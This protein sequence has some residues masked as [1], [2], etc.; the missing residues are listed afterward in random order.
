V[1]AASSVP[2]VLP[3]INPSVVPGLPI[4]YHPGQVIV[5]SPTPPIATIPQNTEVAVV[6]TAI[7]TVARNIISSALQQVKKYWPS[8][9]SSS[10]SE[11]IISPEIV[12]DGS[13]LQT[14]QTPLPPGVTVMHHRHRRTT[15]IIQ[16]HEEHSDTV[17]KGH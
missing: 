12:N 13:E 10:P 5:S 8:S 11:N 9:I 2:A 14:N 3:P 15:T 1:P 7:A 17:V 16:H 6:P 4:P